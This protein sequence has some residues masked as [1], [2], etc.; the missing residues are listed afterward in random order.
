MYTLGDSE[1]KTGEE[2][3]EGVCT[4]IVTCSVQVC[5]VKEH[6][7]DPVERFA[8]LLPASRVCKSTL[9]HWRKRWDL[10]DIVVSQILYSRC[11][12]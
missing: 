5:S 10:A 7:I 4:E 9:G 1:K 3:E 2:E 11:R 6:A 12:C 8:K